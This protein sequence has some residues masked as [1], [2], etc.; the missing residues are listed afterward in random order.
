MNTSEIMITEAQLDEATAVVDDG[1]ESLLGGSEYA[2]E[3]H[4][5][6]RELGE[7]KAALDVVKRF[8]A[9]TDDGALSP[10]IQ[11]SIVE[12]AEFH[13]VW[14]GRKPAD[15]FYLIAKA[16]VD[17]RI[18][19]HDF[20]GAVSLD[21]NPVV[22]GRPQDLGHPTAP[23]VLFYEIRPDTIIA[24]QLAEHVVVTVDGQTVQRDVTP[25]AMAFWFQPDTDEDGQPVDARTGRNGRMYS[26]DTFRAGYK[27]IVATYRTLEDADEAMSELRRAV[28]RLATPTMADEADRLREELLAEGENADREAAARQALRTVRRKA[29]VAI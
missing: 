6:M 8:A 13:A 4:A 22:P 15:S 20:L 27:G 14:T 21:L 9:V 12:M 16:L 24:E 5:A 28:R 11:T 23:A 2:H 7:V 10:T 3:G 26:N 17:R 1:G 18:G 19:K 29:T 25:V